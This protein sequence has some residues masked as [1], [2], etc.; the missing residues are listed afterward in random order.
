M[1]LIYEKKAVPIEVDIR[2]KLAYPPHLHS[3][4]ELVV[5]RRGTARAYLNFKEYPL[6]PGDLFLAFSNQIH[7]YEDDGEAESLLMVF[8]PELCAEFAPLFPAFTPASPRMPGLGDHPALAPIL[9]DLVACREARP[10]YFEAMTKGYLILF[11]AA[12]LPLV[13]L[14]PRKGE[15]DSR[16]REMLDYCAAHYRQPLRLEDLAAALHTSRF[17]LSH[18]FGDR[19]QMG[20]PEYLNSLR[21]AEACERLRR[22]GTPIGTIAAEVGF[23]SLRSF[24][25][26][27]QKERG[28]TPAQYRRAGTAEE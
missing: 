15:D 12:L 21:V 8:P 16:L 6:F 1:S 5:M 26:A 20:F 25:R 18:L 13:G 3:E 17:H 7:H 2:H 23:S 9:R 19:L 4:V 11:T 27:F 14:T 28:V 24:N 10:P 22:E